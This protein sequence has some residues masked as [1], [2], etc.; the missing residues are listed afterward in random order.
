MV[1]YALFSYV[2]ERYL[3]KA[4]FEDMDRHRM[5]IDFK[6]GRRY[7]V[8][9][10]ARAISNALSPMDMSQTVMVCIPASCKRTN[11]RRYKQFS[12]MVC[13]QLGCENGFDYVQVVGK[14]RKAHIN[15]VHELAESVQIDETRLAGKTVVLFDDIVTSCKTANAFIDKIIMAG[16]NVRMAIFLAKTKSFRDYNRIYRSN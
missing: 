6:S 4:S 14:R 9:W 11:D 2:P 16:A 7:A 12:A 5:I 13:E 15:H 8:K 1:K 3:K 10:A